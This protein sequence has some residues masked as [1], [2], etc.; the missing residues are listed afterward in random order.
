M[1]NSRK[2]L[3]MTIL[4][5]FILSSTVFALGDIFKD[6]KD[7][8]DDGKTTAETNKDTIDTSELQ[9]GSNTIYNI[10]LAIGTG[11]AIIVGAV[12][13]IQFMTAGIDKKIEVKQALFPYFISCVILFGAFGIWK[14][15]VTILKSTF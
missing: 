4:V 2:I 14:L 3:I 10:F 15:A 11:V 1:K 12:L 6:G 9:A 8:I 5:F 7:F 13:G